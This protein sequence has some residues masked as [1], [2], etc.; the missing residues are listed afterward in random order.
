MSTIGKL[1]LAIGYP[2]VVPADVLEFA[3]KVDGGEVHASDLEK[4]LVLSREISREEE[5]LPRLASYSTG[6]ILREDAALYWD[7]RRGAAMLAQEIPA[8]AA[9]HALKAFFESFAD[10]CDWW[11][12]RTAAEPVKTAAFPEMVIRP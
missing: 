12:A 1:A 7:G 6:R 5:D 4:R 11:L 8:A 9:P 2:Q 3:F 10:S